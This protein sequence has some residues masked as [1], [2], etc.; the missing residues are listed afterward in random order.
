MTLSDERRLVTVLFADL[1]GFTGRAEQSDPEAVRELQRRYFGAVSAEVERFGGAVEKYIGDAVMAIFGAPQAHDDDAER[2]LRSAIGIRQAVSD[3]DPGLEVRIGVNTGEVVGGMGTGPH[4]ADYTVS[5]DAV[6]VAARLQQNAQP[7]EILVGGTTRALSAEAF[8]FAPLDE[9][10]LKGH[11]QPIEAWRLERELPNRPRLRGGEARLVGR[12]RE[13]ATLESALDEA[14]SGRGLMV[15]LVGEA[16]IGKS[17][18]AL[19]TRRRAEAGGFATAWTT[20]RSYSSAFPY[21]LLAQLVHQLLRS[22]A[23][24]STADVLR[25]RGVAVDDETL[26]RW[27]AVLDDVLG[28]EGNAAPLADLSPAGR[29]RLLVHALSGLLRAVAAQQPWLLIL[30]DLHWADPASL[31]VVEELL[32]V[33]VELRVVILALYRSGWTHGWEAK[34]SYQQLNLR[35]LRIEEAREM[36]RELL[37]GTDAP[38]DLTDR[39]LERSAGNPFFL[40][41]LLRGD[42]SQSLNADAPRRLPESIHEMLL[43]RLDALP[44]EVRQLLQLASVIGMEFPYAVVAALGTEDSNATEMDVDGALRTLQRA[45]LIVPRGVEEGERMLAFRHPLIHEVA[46]RSLLLSTRRSLHGRIARWLE[47]HGGEELLSQL[48]LHYRD[49]DDAAKAREYLPLAAQRA[50]SLNATREA[51]GWYMDAA[52]AFGDDP[53]RRAEMMEAAAR[54]TYLGGDVPTAIEIQRRAIDLYASAGAE[55]AA[56]NGRRVLGRYYWLNGMPAD[57]EEQNQLAITGLER[58][59]PSPELA[60]AYSFRAQMLML[61]PDSAAGAEWARKAISVAR[62]DRRHGSARARLQQ[63]RHVAQWARRSALGRSPA[64]KPG[65]GARIQPDR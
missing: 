32:D 38:A 47:M 24:A 48:A 60:Y 2:A 17:R 59:P 63:S 61:K 35:A 6:N 58:L 9:M 64:P 53:V 55:V 22:D 44:A 33:I 7:G 49:S 42:Q 26:E 36:A 23:G 62:G 51:H 30:D 57:S 18:L 3:V 65:A 29:Q 54:Q 28:E 45:E 41:E 40:E 16:G 56:L 11:A 10:A 46:Y 14:A 27:A 25:A 50:E 12:G 13:L 21:H 37:I 20:S 8:A 5:G 4:S 39:V 1:V 31:A 15:A 34:S 52:T 19:E 43:A